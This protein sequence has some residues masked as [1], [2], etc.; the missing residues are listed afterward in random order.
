MVESMQTSVSGQ[1]PQ[2]ESQHKVKVVSSVSYLTVESE[3]PVSI[4]ASQLGQA[5]PLLIT[6]VSPV[7]TQHNASDT[8]VMA[9]K[10]AHALVPSS[11]IPEPDDSFGS[12]SS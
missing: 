11:G 1:G 10:L 9:N 12:S 6:H 7:F 3:L 4:Y 5:R 8:V 2:S